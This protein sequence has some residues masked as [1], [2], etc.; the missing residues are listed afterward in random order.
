MFIKMTFVW[1]CNIGLQLQELSLFLLEC[2]HHITKW[3][4]ATEKTKGR[5]SNSPLKSVFDSSQLSGSINVIPENKSW[6]ALQNTPA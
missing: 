6:I 4:K 5:P 2:I 1:F 3:W